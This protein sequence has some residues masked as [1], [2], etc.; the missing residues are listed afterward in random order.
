MRRTWALLN[1]T[2]V[3]AFAAGCSSDP[4]DG[5]GHNATTGGTTGSGTGGSSGSAGTSGKGSSSA[6]T[7]ASAIAHL[8]ADR[9]IPC[10]RST[11]ADGRRNDSALETVEP[12]R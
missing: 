12:A 2:I 9:R 3:L 11:S 5:S 1:S 4:A 10:G 7:T 6:T 8:G